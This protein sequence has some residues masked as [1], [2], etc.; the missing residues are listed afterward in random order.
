VFG[1]SR[2]FR[3][4]GADRLVLSLWPVGDAQAQ[5]WMVELYGGALALEND[6]ESFSVWRTMQDLL[7]EQRQHGL[8]THPFHWGAFVVIGTPGRFD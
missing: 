1:L 3:I 6:N 4:A 2:A 5:R 8:S 7:A